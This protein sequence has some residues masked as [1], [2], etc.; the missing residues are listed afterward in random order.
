MPSIIL[1]IFVLLISTFS[2]WGFFKL[3]ESVFN[4]LLFST[5]VNWIFLPAG[6]RLLLTLLFAEEG[7]IGITIASIAIGINHYFTNDVLTAVISGAISGIA[8]Y[9]A[10]LIVLNKL[11]LKSDLTNLSLGNL[12][13]CILIFAVISPLMHQ[14]WFYY[15]GYT[16]NFLTSLSVMTLGDF[17]G[18]LIVIYSAKLLINIWRGLTIVKS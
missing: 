3:N 10:R 13:L 12:F 14:L 18:S 7:A 15:A 4:D 16:Q 2:Y 1:N 5:G 8:P 9:V 17:I 11:R 6:L